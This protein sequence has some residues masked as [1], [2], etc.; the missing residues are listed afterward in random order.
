MSDT[1]MSAKKREAS[2]IGQNVTFFTDIKNPLLISRF[3]N[4]GW[5]SIPQ[6][7]LFWTNSLSPKLSASYHHIGHSRIQRHQRINHFPNSEELCRKDLLAKNVH[8]YMKRSHKRLDSID[9][10]PSTYR[11]PGQYDEFA[12]THTDA[13]NIW[14]MKPVDRCQGDGIFLANKLSEVKRRLANAQQDAPR[15]SSEYLISRYIERPLLIGGRKFDLRLYVLVT[16]FRPLRAYLYKDGFCRV[17]CE[18]YTN[19]SDAL[20]DKF[21]HLTNVSVQKSSGKF[22]AAHGGKWSLKW[23]QL[24]LDQTRGVKV[25][26]Q[27]FASIEAVIRH[28]LWA[29]QPHIHSGRNFFEC[30]GYDILIDGA[31]KP[32]L[33]EVNSKP[34]L[35]GT[36]LS[37]CELKTRLI[38][39]ILNIVFDKQKGVANNFKLLINEKSTKSKPFLSTE[40]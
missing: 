13:S 21:V 9:F 29:V 11:L 5:T 40:G 18:Q 19:R 31:M 30:Y 26:R 32:W 20:H 34:S 24:W 17:C 35:H 23:L 25:R 1:K 38:D 10:L 12:A 4:R 2:V 16:S 15:A 27:L 8:R 37:D 39:H 3:E 36:T 7:D 28:S 14:I 22:N 6:W 33:I